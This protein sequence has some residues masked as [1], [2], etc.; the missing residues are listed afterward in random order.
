[1]PED[2]N[3]DELYPHNCV[4]LSLL[5]T[6]SLPGPCI[7]F[8]IFDGEEGCHSK[9]YSGDLKAI[10]VDTWPTIQ[11]IHYWDS[12]VL[13]NTKV[14]LRIIRRPFGLFS[15]PNGP[16]FLYNIPPASHNT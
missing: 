11:I 3:Q 7:F 8:L 1:M 5:K 16:F 4:F 6:L 12:V 2:E 13:E 14:F 9:V 15:R 10:P